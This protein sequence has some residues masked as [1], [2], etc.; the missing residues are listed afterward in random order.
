MSS[1]SSPNAR[2]KSS[3]TLRRRVIHSPARF[4]PLSATIMRTRSV[5]GLCSTVST[6]TPTIQ[7]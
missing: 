7:T 5:C 6:G 4:T 3:T 1:G 2:R